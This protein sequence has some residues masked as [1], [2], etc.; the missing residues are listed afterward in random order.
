MNGRSVRRKVGDL[1]PSHLIF[2][3]GVGAIVDLPS[4]SVMVMGLDD[5]DVAHNVEIGEERLL[6]AVQAQLGEQVERL[7]SPPLAPDFGS[8]SNPLDESAHLGVPVAPF[9]RWVRCPWC[10]LLAPLNSGLFELKVHPYRPDRT[11]YVHANCTKPGT[12]PTVLPARFLV[13]CKLGHLD[14]FP[15]VAYVHRGPTECRA[16]LRLR[17]Y[18]VSG[19]A[20]DVEVRC[21]ACGASRRMADAFGGD[22]QQALPVCRARRPHLRDFQDQACHEPVKSILLGASNSWFP[23]TLSALSV[24]TASN[25]LAQRVDEHWVVLE[26]ATTR[27]VLEAFRQ[28]GQ[29]RAFAQFSDDAL[30]SAITARRDTPADEGDAEKVRDLKR[31]EW[32]V[33]SQPDPARNSADFHL[34]PVGPPPRYERFFSKIVLVERLREVR[35]LIGF[36]RIESPGD[37]EDVGEIPPDRQAPL[38]R[39]PPRWVPGS[40]VRGEGI[41]LEFDEKSVAGWCEAAEIVARD[42]EFREAHRQWRRARWIEP[43]EAGFPG[44]RYVLLHSFAH[45]LMR[46]LALECGYTAASIRERIYSREPYADDGPMAGVLLYTAAPDSEGTL[47]GLVSLG[48][49]ET[50]TRH[51]EQALEQMR[52]CASDPLCAEHHPHRDGVTL[53]GA[54]CHACLFAPETSCERGNKYLDRTLLVRTF[55]QASGAFFDREE[56]RP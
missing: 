53:H 31:P 39:R 55:G 17:E 3:F 35:A 26:K 47:G 11:R 43:A 18:G 7:F 45:A 9:P 15:W 8:P 28:I 29:L 22:A 4:L 56:S 46:Q 13:A 33:F 54:A 25:R 21:D 12:P 36:T 27:E 16:L 40:E 52:L 32:S 30:W 41:F 24:P 34:T 10:H 1:S 19:E 2:T 38:A 6:A 42:R 49:P 20:T 48:K 37:F 14:D 44:I 5:W 51:I 23:I 50:L